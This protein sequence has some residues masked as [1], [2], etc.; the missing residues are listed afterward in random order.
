M[1]SYGHK[2]N[3]IRSP[4]AIAMHAS[5]ATILGLFIYTISHHKAINNNNNN[6]TTLN[7]LYIFKTRGTIVCNLNLNLSLDSWALQIFS[8]YR[9]SVTRP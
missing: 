1:S 9:S 6:I 5:I 8:R 3:S 4:G 2:H 7:L